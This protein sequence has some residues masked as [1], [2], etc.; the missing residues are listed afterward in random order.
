MD[1]EACNDIRHYLCASGNRFCHFLLSMSA[2]TI[3]N[4]LNLPHPPKRRRRETVGE[5]VRFNLV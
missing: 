1:I 5:K 2:I 4:G 3:E